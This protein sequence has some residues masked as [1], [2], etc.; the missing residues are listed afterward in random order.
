M[1]A[2]IP[3]Q[4]TCSFCWRSSPGFFS[5]NPRQSACSQGVD[6]CR[7]RLQAKARELGISEKVQFLGSRDDV[8]EL[9]RGADLL[10]LP[11]LFEGLGL[12][13]VEAQA[14]GLRSLISDII[15]AE[16]EVVQNLVHRLALG[17]P[18]V[19][20]SESAL[21]LL[22][23]PAPEPQVG[24]RAVEASP[25]NITNSAKSLMALYNA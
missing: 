19:K 20:W 13:V 22:K 12:V 8:P 1:W 5:G 15:P 6:R 21:E 4:R 2:G 25:F 16:V 24:L 14:V 18:S 11:S 10:L 17:A 9:M 23:Q 7:P 3:S